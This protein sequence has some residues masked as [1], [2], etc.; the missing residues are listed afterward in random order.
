MDD[1]S[2][3]TVAYCG[4]ENCPPSRG[5][6]DIGTALRRAVRSTQHGVLVR[7]GCL[8]ELLRERAGCPLAGSCQRETAAAGAFV[9]VQPCDATRR[10]NGPAHLAGPL[11][12]DADL[13]ELCRWLEQELHLGE[14]LPEHLRP[15]LAAEDDAQR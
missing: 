1:S 12:E 9:L 3:F 2:G 13:T 4:E 14:P 5:G 6:P 15:L 8:L 10:P 7:S 11:H